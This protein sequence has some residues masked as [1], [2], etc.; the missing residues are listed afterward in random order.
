MNYYINAQSG[1]KKKTGK[2]V[3]YVFAYAA[4]FALSFFISFKLVA[5]TQSGAE[6]I[7]VLKEEISSL[8]SQLAQREERITS[9]EMQLE[10][11]QRLLENERRGIG[12]T[13]SEEDVPK[14]EENTEAENEKQ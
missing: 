9:L 7:G 5:S 8:N 3:L 2:I 14:T 4:V 12:E 6:E 13:R 1:K 11:V 10:S